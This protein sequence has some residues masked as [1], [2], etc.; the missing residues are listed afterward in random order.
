MDENVD[1][2]IT[3]GL[4]RCG[5]DVVRVQDYSAVYEQPDEVVLAWTTAEDRVLVTND[6]NTMESARQLEEVG[7]CSL[8]VYLRPQSRIGE[9]IEDIKL[10]NEC[11]NPDDWDGGVK[12]LPLQ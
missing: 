6:R 12:W 11:S 4:L 10:L 1:G 3:R 7:K 9:V 2:S 8:I 5:I